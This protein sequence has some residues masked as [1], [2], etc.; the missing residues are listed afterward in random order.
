MLSRKIISATICIVSLAL[1]VFY[2]QGWVIEGENVQQWRN[3]ISWILNYSVA[4]MQSLLI[5]LLIPKEYKYIKLFCWTAFGI[6]TAELLETMWCRI[7]S[8]DVC[9]NSFISTILVGL[10]ICTSLYRSIVYLVNLIRSGRVTG[11]ET[12][13]ISGV[14]MRGIIGLLLMIFHT[15][16]NTN[17]L[18]ITFTT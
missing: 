8:N 9:E 5:A 1:I 17:D 10:I 3:I 7:P 16:Y 2:S 18:R 13:I 15:L 4:P 11:K 6:Y 12:T 14:T